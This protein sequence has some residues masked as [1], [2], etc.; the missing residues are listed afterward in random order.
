MAEMAERLTHAKRVSANMIRDPGFSTPY[1]LTKS[2]TEPGLRVAGMQFCEQVAVLVWHRLTELEERYRAD[3][4]SI[5]ELGSADD[6]VSRMVATIPTPSPW[7]ETLGPFYGPGKVARVLGGVSRQA[8]ADRRGRSTLLGLKT[9]DGKW[10]YPAFQF[11]AHHKVL[12][13]L[14]DVVRCLR[15]TDLDDWT[16]ASWLMTSRQELEGLSVVRWLA[17]GRAKDRPLVLA[18]QAADRLAQ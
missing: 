16:L 6:F 17:E 13:G 10:V 8:I 18:R 11:D 7:N 9:A 15:S 4:R 5:E 12:E 3:G 14:P 1:R 2:G